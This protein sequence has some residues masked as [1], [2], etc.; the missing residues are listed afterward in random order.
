[1][2][3]I[4][5]A[6]LDAYEVAVHK[7]LEMDGNTRLSKYDV[8]EYLDGVFDA[9]IESNLRRERAEMKASRLKLRTGIGDKE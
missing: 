4:Y 2:D 8:L 3:A 1:M 7:T 6:L 9:V 5:D